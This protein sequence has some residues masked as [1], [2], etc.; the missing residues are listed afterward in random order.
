ME[1]SSF[2]ARVGQAVVAARLPPAPAADPGLV[3]PELGEVDLVE[4]FAERL[5]ALDGTFHGAASPVVVIADIARRLGVDRYLGW[6]EAELPVPG[7][8]ARLAAVGLKRLDG[9][10]TAEGRKVHQ[11]GYFDVEL[12]V[13]GAEAAFAQSGSVVLRS[14]PGRPRMA[15][16]VPLVHVVLLHPADIHRSL[17]HW[18]EANA[19]S[20]ADAANVVF[21]TGP[22]RTGDI[23]QVLTLGVHGPQELHVVLVE[24]GPRGPAPS[25]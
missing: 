16:L 7:L 9:V 14:G 12:G 21:I 25:R 1:R 8:E 15:S 11:A 17:A 3:V 24:P 10:V 22:S 13:T 20:V 4:L 6:E 23:E 2:L 5:T 19:G 18:A